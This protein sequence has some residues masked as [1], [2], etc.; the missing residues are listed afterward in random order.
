MSDIAPNDDAAPAALVS[1][2]D[3]GNAVDEVPTGNAWAEHGAMVIAGGQLPANLGGR[4]VIAVE[5]RVPTY[6]RDKLLTG[7]TPDVDPSHYP[8][9]ADV[10]VRYSEDTP[11]PAGGQVLTMGVDLIQFGFG[12][13]SPRRGAVCVGPASAVYA[14]VN[15][16][17][18]EGA[19]D[20]KV[21]GLS[22]ADRAHLAPW[23]G[24]ATEA[25][26]QS[27]RPFLSKLDFGA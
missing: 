19:T 6:D 9:K 1:G 14:A 13:L 17:F 24:T 3:T 22:D 7:S 25:L 21:V 16:A 10:F 8:D 4:K 27:K 15:V 5:L 20:V 12:G 11:A 18:L 26:D 23:F 2:Q